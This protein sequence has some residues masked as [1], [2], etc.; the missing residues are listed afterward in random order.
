MYTDFRVRLRAARE[1]RGYKS[2]QSF[3]D[4]FG[5][6]QS[7]VGGWE[8]GSR[9]PTYQTLVRLA[10]F[11]RVS[12]DYL[13]GLTENENGPLSEIGEEALDDE[14]ISRVTALSPEDRQKVDFFVQGIEAARGAEASP[15]AGERK[16]PL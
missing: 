2:Q 14:L 8:A 1:L 10:S 11:L 6:A 7:T 16:S 13:L 3:A 5:V 12:V 4:A 15:A 9:E